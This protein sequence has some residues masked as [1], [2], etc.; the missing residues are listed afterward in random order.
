MKILSLICLIILGGAV[1]IGA[2]EKV[3]ATLQNGIYFIEVSGTPYEMG[4]QH[5]VALKDQ[6]ID[7]VADYKASVKKL[8]GE[9]NAQLIFY[10]VLNEA[11]FKQDIEKQIPNVIEELKG[12]ADGAGVS[13][14]DV[15]LT[16]M[17]E[18]VYEAAPSRFGLKPINAPRQGGTSFTVASGKKRFSGQNM[19]YSG[20][21]QGKQLVIRYQYSNRQ[22]LTYGFVGQIGGVGVNS[23]GLSVFVTTLPQ[24]KKREQDGLGSTFVRRMLLEQNSVD[25]AIAKLAATPR[26]AGTNYIL[27]D[28]TKGV[29]IESDAA[30]AIL[31][32]QT[33]EKPFVVGTNHVLHLNHRHDIPGLYENG[34][35][36]R[37]SISLTIE[38]MAYAENL[39]TSAGTDLNTKSLKGL[40]TVTPVNIYHP[41]FMT[42]ESGIVEYDVDKVYFYVSGGYDPLRK[43]N[44]Y[45]F[46]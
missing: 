40:L 33:N 28:F 39:I 44:E 36:L 24:G 37:S 30:D 14:D 3:G 41:A 20:N 32:E 2:G 1:D 22:L 25:S 38:R 4:K 46:D 35:A 29:I 43:W 5:G 9:E 19:E 18:E 34:E 42:L 31:R 27:T 8:F 45:T 7:A 23:N 13:F 17:F 15:L 6:I 11:K 21:L 26:F 10:W 12:I 16:N